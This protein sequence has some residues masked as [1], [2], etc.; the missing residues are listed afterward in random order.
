MLFVR[1]INLCDSFH[2][3][4]EFTK[5]E[6]RIIIAVPNNRRKLRIRGEAR[7]FQRGGPL[8][9]SEGAHQIGT[10]AKVSSWHFR[11]LL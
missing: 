1:T 10:M 11:H 2:H 7:T 9:Q 3:F 4:L 6:M 5:H 8:C